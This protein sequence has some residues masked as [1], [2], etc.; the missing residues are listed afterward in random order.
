[1]EEIDSRTRPGLDVFGVGEHHRKDYLD[2]APAMISRQRPPPRTKRIR[3]TSAVTASLSSAD[4]VR[5]FQNFATSRFSLPGKGGNGRRS[6]G[7]S[8]ILSLSSV[9]SSMTTTSS[10]RKSS[11]LLLK[12]RENE[13]VTRWANP[14]AGPVRTGGIS[15]DLSS[16]VS[17][18]IWLG[19]G[20][21]SRS[22]VR[23][24]ELGLPLMVAII[25]GEHAPLPPTDRSL[26]VRPGR[27]R[28]SLRSA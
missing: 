5:V 17:L 6:R 21:T 15:S 19:V 27:G 24:G 25:G 23:A 16:V 12:V 10:S 13:H 14:P 3:L 9:S 4:P 28:A 26:S 18:P 7:S 1:M 8:L 11:N 20:G 2:S 22:F